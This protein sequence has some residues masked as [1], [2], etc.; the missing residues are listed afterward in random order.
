MRRL[1]PLLLALALLPAAE[2]R[3]QSEGTTTLDFGRAERVTGTA[4]AEAFGGR[5]AL[6]V[7]TGRAGREWR[8]VHR[9]TVRLR[10]R[11]LTGFELRL[12][13]TRATVRA[14]QAGRT[15]TLLRGRVRATLSRRTGRVRVRRARLRPAVA[16]IPAARLEVLARV[17]P[18]GSATIRLP[19]RPAGAVDVTGGQVDWHV[20]DSLVQYLNAGGGL[21]ARDGARAGA[22]TTR[23]GSS[24][25]LVYDIAL[26]VTG[27]WHDARTGLTL[28]RLRGS[29]GFRYRAHGIDFTVAD[30]AVEL[31]GGRPSRATFRF[32][33]EAGERFQARRAPLMDLL[34]PHGAEYPGAVPRER[35]V[36]S[37]FY[38][39]GD[40]FGWM[41]IAFTTR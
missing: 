27:G 18:R 8:V 6:P 33:G 2:A 7:L 21:R 11:R 17:D 32:S 5:V 38:Q 26:P 25:R 14:R 29:V 16:G 36:F 19:A 9:G 4:G 28:L 41:T 37:G 22:P 23:P 15:R 30:G 39:P 31:G 13:R 10:G 40:P 20:R 35:T 3:A 1:A 34:A 24:E 12:T